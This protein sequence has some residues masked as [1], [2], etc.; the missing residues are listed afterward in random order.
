MMDFFS[1]ALNSLDSLLST[2]SLKQ[3]N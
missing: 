2:S 3:R 1:R